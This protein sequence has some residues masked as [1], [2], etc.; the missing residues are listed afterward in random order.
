M[1]PLA[2]CLG[3]MGR[4]LAGRELKSQQ[5]ARKEANA[6]TT[7]LQAIEH[8]DSVDA[9]LKGIYDT[10]IQEPVPQSLLDLLNDLNQRKVIPLEAR[11]A[12]R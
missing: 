2:G 1:K 3:R 7:I 10:A 11:N 8:G 6:V 5:A 12:P 4:V 9:S